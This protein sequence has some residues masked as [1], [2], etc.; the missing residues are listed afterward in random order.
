VNP[1]TLSTAIY[2]LSYSVIKLSSMN[3]WV[4][5]NKIRCLLWTDSGYPKSLAEIVRCSS[6]PRCTEFPDNVI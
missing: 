5:S 6:T 1:Q 3:S 4:I 2:C